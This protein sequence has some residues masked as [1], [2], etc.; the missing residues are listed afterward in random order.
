[1]CWVSNIWLSC[2]TERARWP[3]ITS[4]SKAGTKV[5]TKPSSL[6]TSAHTEG[7]GTE[8][9]SE[10]S[11]TPLQQVGATPGGYSMGCATGRWHWHILVPPSSSSLPEGGSGLEFYC[12]IAKWTLNLKGRNLWNAYTVW[13]WGFF[14]HWHF[15]SWPCAMKCGWSLGMDVSWHLWV[16]VLLLHSP[17][18]KHFFSF[19]VLIVSL[20]E[21]WPIYL[22][23]CHCAP[24]R[25]AWLKHCST[26]LEH[27]LKASRRTFMRCLCLR[28]EVAQTL[29]LQ[30]KL[31]RKS[32][33]I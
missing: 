7:S 13:A 24:I 12:F 21:S 18:E 27:N 30:P 1:M 33:C 26:W 15:Y 32:I 4:P 16:P 14:V 3:C 17:W 20:Y 22:C 5:S 23:S 10:S 31:N 28:R 19:H 8:E 25:K 6:A 11:C 29:T 9:G 2:S